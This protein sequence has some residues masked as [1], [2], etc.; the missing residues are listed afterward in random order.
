[1]SF[2]LAFHVVTIR[3]SFAIV[4]TRCPF[5]VQI[6][7]VPCANWAEL[8]AVAASITPVKV[9]PCRWLCCVL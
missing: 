2:S 3:N 5:R 9:R 1:L 4:T 7:G 8:Q 6:M